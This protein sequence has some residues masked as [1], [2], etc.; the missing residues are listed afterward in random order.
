MFLTALQTETLPTGQWRLITPLRYREQSGDVIE[1]RVGYVTDLFSVPRP[2]WPLFPRDGRRRPA[3]VVHDYIYTDLT[4]RYTRR[5]ADRIF[6]QA[7]AELDERYFTCHRR[8]FRCI[9]LDAAAERLARLC[10]SAARWTMWAAVRLG[11][12]GNW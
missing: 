5:S 3:A 7:M 2:A 9:H 8:P 1:V 4:H 12:R 11:G 10:A 6:R